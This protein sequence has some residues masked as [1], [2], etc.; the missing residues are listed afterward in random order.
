M[1]RCFGCSVHSEDGAE[2]NRSLLGAVFRH[3]IL[4]LLS[5]PYYFWGENN[6][7]FDII[8][9]SNCSSTLCLVLTSNSLSLVLL[10]LPC[11]CQCTARPFN[12]LIPQ[13]RTYHSLWKQTT[14]K[15]NHLFAR[16][17]FALSLHLAF[18]WKK[19]R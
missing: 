1:N 11:D 12:L 4:T 17:G 9:S 3:I 19:A 15:N 7:T 2:L 13:V 6:L 10:S 16:A 18:S 8:L 5:L 14:N